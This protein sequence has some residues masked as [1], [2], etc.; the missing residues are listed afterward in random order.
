MFR[1]ILLAEKEKFIKLI[2]CEV[3]E[4]TG[5]EEV[6]L[7]CGKDIFM[8]NKISRKFM[9]DKVDLYQKLIQDMESIQL[10]KNQSLL[11]P[12]AV[13]DGLGEDIREKLIYFVKV[14]MKNCMIF[15][16]MLE[17]LTID[18]L[19]GIPNKNAFIDRIEEELQRSVR[20]GSKFA[21]LFLD[22]D[23]FKEINDKKG[24]LEGDK[25][26]K[27]IASIVRSIIRKSDVV[28]RFGGDEFTVL[29]LDINKSVVDCVTKRIKHQI[30]SECDGVSISIG[31][32]I[33]PDDGRTIEELIK[34]SD[35]N[36]YSDKQNKA[37]S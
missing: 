11:L 19:C 1:P 22:V 30:S 16:S 34:I 26:L 7:L 24:H 3:S 27:K 23:N 31:R 36:M 13:A 20:T 2:L 37:N 10:E 35:S 18:M 4:S 12:K 6:C 32:A 28:A 33:Y 14:N 25:L 9:S 5:A 8:Y 17:K 15:N 21:I 29:L